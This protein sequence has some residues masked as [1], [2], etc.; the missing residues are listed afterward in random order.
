MCCAVSHKC[1]ANIVSYSQTGLTEILTQKWLM[2]KWASSI[3]SFKSTNPLM[4]VCVL[5]I[6]YIFVFVVLVL[7][8]ESSKGFDCSTDSSSCRFGTADALKSYII[9]TTTVFLSEY[10]SLPPVES[11]SVWG[12]AQPYKQKKTQT[13]PPPRWHQVHSNT[14]LWSSPACVIS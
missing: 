10:L 3:T 2:S 14:C 11:G 5:N 1:S 8:W 9:F 7:C 12:D 13:L 6:D 4:C